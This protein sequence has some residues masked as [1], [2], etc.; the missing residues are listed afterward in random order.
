MRLTEFEHRMLQRVARGEDPWQNALPGSIPRG[1]TG[2]ID[3]LTRKQAIRFG[4]QP[5]ARYVLTAAA[6]AYLLEHCSHP[7]VT[8]RPA[9]ADVGPWL[10]T[11]CGQEPPSLDIW[12]Q[13]LTSTGKNPAPKP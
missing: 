11:M 6:R 1:V 9:S 3:R 2:A 13:D 8:R 5:G 12:P 10:C 7:G 4:T